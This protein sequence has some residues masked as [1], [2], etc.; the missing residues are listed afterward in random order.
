M[1]DLGNSYDTLVQDCEPESESVIF[2]VQDTSAHT[3]VMISKQIMMIFSCA[4]LMLLAV[5]GRGY[6]VV[7]GDGMMRMDRYLGR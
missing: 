6:G 1:S 4:N 5:I 3:K 2:M 7:G